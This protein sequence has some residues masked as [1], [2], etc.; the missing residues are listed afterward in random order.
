MRERLWANRKAVLLVSVAILSLLSASATLKFAQA[1]KLA[2]YLYSIPYGSVKSE[3]DNPRIHAG[4]YPDTLKWFKGRE[5]KFGLQALIAC[6]KTEP[7][8]L[9]TELVGVRAG[10][11]NVSD[12]TIHLGFANYSPNK[13][14]RPPEYTLFIDGPYNYPRVI[15]YLGDDVF[16]GGPRTK[17]QNMV[18]IPPGRVFNPSSDS[19]LYNSSDGLFSFEAP[20]TYRLWFTYS[21]DSLTSSLSV[22]LTSISSDTIELEVIAPRFTDANRLV[23]FLPRKIDG[24]KSGKP[25]VHNCLLNPHWTES[26]QYPMVWKHYFRKMDDFDAP[27]I[28]VFIVDSGYIPGILNRWHRPGMLAESL[29]TTIKGFPT[30]K[31]YRRSGQQTPSLAVISVTVAERVVVRIDGRGVQ[32]EKLENV[33]RAVDY[34]AMAKALQR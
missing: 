13:H 14:G 28:G 7:E 31:Q 15:G 27:Y 26:L 8:Y 6:N 11:R 33:A 18:S 12:S 29:E 34:A 30:C 32:M 2:S 17:L 16:W 23:K 19:L 24:F 10:I 5:S 21:F 22:S 9:P 3:I 20:G 1:E 25:E 4:L